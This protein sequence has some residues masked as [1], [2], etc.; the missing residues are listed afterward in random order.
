MDIS[1]TTL[2]ALDEQLTELVKRVHEAEKELARRCE[3]LSANAPAKP[4]AL[5][6]LPQDVM[7]I[8]VRANRC[9]WIDESSIDDVRRHLGYNEAPF[10][11]NGWNRAWYLRCREV[12]TAWEEWEPRYEAARIA[13]GVPEQFAILEKLDDAVIELEEQIF[14]MRARTLEGLR[15]KA[16]IIDQY[17]F[18]GAPAHERRVKSLVADLLG[19]AGS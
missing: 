15:V 19:E 11:A 5:R 3:V 16:K 8:G 6:V 1:D 9:P 12:I 4:E 10:K 2:L 13:I 17:A 7:A 18:T 14:A